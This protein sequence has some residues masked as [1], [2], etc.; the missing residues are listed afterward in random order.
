MRPH[1]YLLA[2]SLS[3][4]RRGCVNDAAVVRGWPRVDGWPCRLCPEMAPDLE[5]PR[6]PFQKEH[7]VSKPA[8]RVVACVAAVLAL[9]VTLA[10]QVPDQSEVFEAT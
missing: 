7:V 8:N 3:T 9:F 5:E 1:L 4:P 10:G 2:R 6:D